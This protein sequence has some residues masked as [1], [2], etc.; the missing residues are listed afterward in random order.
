MTNQIV[1]KQFLKNTGMEVDLASGGNEALRLCKV[2]KYDVVLMDH[3]MPSPDG[4]ETLHLIRS[5]EG[6]LNRETPVIVLTANA[7]V[8]SRE[9]Y[10][11]EGFDNYL[12][13]PVESGRLIKMIR[14]YLP[15]EKVL[16]KPRK[17]T[18]EG[19]TE[20]A[21]ATE[22]AAGFDG[23][24]PVDIPALLARFDNQQQTVNL[25]LEEVIKEGE[26][27]IPL[28]RELVEKEDIK[29]YAVEAHGIKGVMASSC[30][31]DLSDTAKAHELAAKGDNFGYVKD[32]IDSFIRQY[33][34]VL[35]FIREYLK[36]QG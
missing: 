12:S 8:G 34:E 1:V 20:N 10:E 14:K 4:I 6:S 19:Q 18:G 32:N 35:D 16:Y 29:R 27:K 13:K 2:N 7:L 23:K 17:R 9:K 25:I 26:R 36:G 33:E 22:A 11:A 30:A 31:P 15:E 5:D 28:L 24:T 21:P 3:M